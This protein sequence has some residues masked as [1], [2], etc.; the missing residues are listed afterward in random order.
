M[1]HNNS[2]KKI[3]PLV[4][5]PKEPKE[6]G[7]TKLEAWGPPIET[8]PIESQI[9]SKKQVPLTTEI[10]LDSKKPTEQH[11]PNIRLE[12]VLGPDK[13]SQEIMS[14]RRPPTRSARSEML[15]YKLEKV[16]TDL[17]KIN[18]SKSFLEAVN[19]EINKDLNAYK[20]ST[21]IHLKKY[22]FLELLRKNTPDNKTN[23]YEFLNKQNNGI[24]FYK[25][26]PC[27]EEE[28][29]LYDIYF[30]LYELKFVNTDGLFGKK[31]HVEDKEQLLLTLYNCVLFPPEEEKEEKIISKS[32]PTTQ[33]KRREQLDESKNRKISQKLQEDNKLQENVSKY[34]LDKQKKETTGRLTE[35]KKSNLIKKHLAAAV[36]A[37]QK[38]KE[39]ESRLKAIADAEE[40]AR[41]KAIADAEEATRLTAIADAEEATR[42]KAIAD[43]EEATR[44]KAIADAEEAARLKSDSEELIKQHISAA[45]HSFQK[46]HKEEEF[47]RDAVNA[48]ELIKHH[49]IA[50]I[51]TFQ[52]EREAETL[53]IQK[54]KKK[55]TPEEDKFQTETNAE[56]DEITKR[57]LE[58]ISKI[59]NSVAAAVASEEQ[60]QA[61]EKAKDNYDSYIAAAIAS[62]PK[63]EEK[64]EPDEN[65]KENAKDNYDS[66]IAASIASS[67]QK[68]DKQGEEYQQKEDKQGEEKADE[69]YE[70]YIA[71]AIASS[72]E[73]KEKQQ[74]PEEKAKDNY[75]SYIAA[76]I[77]SSQPK[78]E[79]KQ[80]E[81]KEE[82]EKDN[83]DSYIA[84]AIASQPKEDEQGEEDKQDK[85][86]EEKEEKENYESYV[87]TAVAAA[88]VT[89]VASSQKKGQLPLVAEEKDSKDNDESKPE[90]TIQN[91]EPDHKHVAAAISTAIK[92]TKKMISTTVSELTL[93]KF[94]EVKYYLCYLNT[95]L[96]LLLNNKRFCYNIQKSDAL[97][98][99]I[100]S[101]KKLV[102]DYYEPSTIKPIN[103]TD[104]KDLFNNESLGIKKEFLSETCENVL[105]NLITTFKPISDDIFYISED[106]V[107]PEEIDTIEKIISNNNNSK[108]NILVSTKFLKQDS[109]IEEKYQNYELVSFITKDYNFYKK[110][111]Q[112]G[113]I[114]GWRQYGDNN[115][116]EIGSELLRAA[117]YLEY[118]R[119]APYRLEYS[120]NLLSRNR[121]MVNY[122][123]PVNAT[124]Q[125]KTKPPQVVPEP[126]LEPVVTSIAATTPFEP[127]LE[128][129]AASIAATK[130]ETPLELEPDVTKPETPQLEPVAASIAATTP[131]PQLEPD[132]TNLETPQLEPVAASIAATT[133][134][135][136]LE[137][138]APNKEEPIEYVA[139]A[140]RANNQPIT[141]DEFKQLTPEQKLNVLTEYR[142]K[143]YFSSNINT[144]PIR[145]GVYKPIMDQIINQ[146]VVQ[147]DKDYIGKSAEYVNEQYS[148]WYND[149]LNGKAGGT[150]KRR[151]ASLKKY[152]KRNRNKTI[153]IR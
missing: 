68:K 140:I 130:R 153:R 73:T 8:V 49:V 11:V 150:R 86:P 112:M 111:L 139:A 133:P 94:V 31:K 106:N 56:A 63:K 138:V 24:S 113:D 131:E 12:S 107:K 109:V 146:H 46:E 119:I 128:S 41:L 38:E 9:D 136:Q 16:D 64:Q 18:Q 51:R 90:P 43:A 26:M 67:Q 21:K 40:A 59:F 60:E 82:Q 91:V 39:E 145:S 123:P 98:K 114:Y 105:H 13:T 129:V 50:A 102:N 30:K 96:L 89:A 124:E 27:G 80:G 69:N 45:I 79:E 87:S 135:P 144:T 118:Q 15:S 1:S 104:Y 57:T 10:P 70:S 74:E 33:Q 47:A 110:Y 108:P 42:L 2:Q 121:N 83:Y 97:V 84:A 134:E 71:A 132:V 93:T 58:R 95:F 125:T 52:Q 25:K 103:I 143:G 116:V 53:A 142:N 137:T 5:K 37:F 55:L 77:A 32:R 151:T 76:A 88:I 3:N 36:R 29:S 72:Q 17:E 122:K 81:E 44:L 14:A 23:L 148:K 141:P 147:K 65:A 85:Q 117:A 126:Q 54:S 75:E 101:M 62:Q 22:D 149:N 48:E 28:Y 120:D 92:N 100:I 115:Q 99:N 35:Q 20:P 66:Y 7:L 4:N 61:E 152:R 6:S 127:Q 34:Y 78:K 19:Q